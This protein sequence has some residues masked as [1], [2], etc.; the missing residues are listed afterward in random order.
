M[1]KDTTQTLVHIPM[2]VI[3]NYMAWPMDNDSLCGISAHCGSFAMQSHKESVT[4]VKVKGVTGERRRTRGG[5]RAGR[6]LKAKL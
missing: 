6:N 2:C 4:G 3:P 1:K 5:R